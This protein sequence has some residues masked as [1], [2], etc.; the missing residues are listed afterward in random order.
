MAVPN[1]D[2]FVIEDDSEP[3]IV[4]TMV[5]DEDLPPYIT[6]IDVIDQNTPIMYTRDQ[7]MVHVLNTITHNAPV[8]DAAKFIRQ[9]NEFV[10]VMMALSTPMSAAKSNSLLCPILAG[11][12]SVVVEEDE[13]DDEDVLTQLGSENSAPVTMS[14][15]LNKLSKRSN[16]ANLPY[17]ALVDS[18]YKA[19]QTFVSNQD[20][21]AGYPTIQYSFEANTRAF[22]VGSPVAINSHSN[23]NHTVF[24]GNAFYKGDSLN[25]IGFVYQGHRDTLTNEKYELIDSEAYRT[26][27]QALDVGDEVVVYHHNRISKSRCKVTVR[28]PG[29]IEAR[30][31]TSEAVYL[32]HTDSIWKNDAFAFGK[33][34]IGAPFYMGSILA[35]GLAFT[36]LANDLDGSL[37]INS[38]LPSVD[39][40]ISIYNNRNK[41]DRVDI[42][43]ILSE[44]GYATERIA[45]ISQALYATTVETGSERLTKHI[46]SLRDVYV[47][48][49][50]N[51]S[52]PKMRD[53]T[54][55]GYDDYKF[56]KTFCDSEY[57]R[58]KH[59]MSQ[60]DN[61]LMLA[62]AVAMDA[63]KAAEKRAKESSLVEAPVPLADATDAADAADDAEC[64]KKDIAKQCKKT[65]TSQEAM[66][67]DN[68]RR[69]DEV[70]AGDYAK[71]QMDGT[72]QY[73]RRFKT[74][75]GAEE[76]VKDM[77][78]H[79]RSL[80][81][82]DNVVP[83][84]V[85]TLLESGC[86]YDDMKRVCA[87]L[88]GV[89]KKYAASN[90]RRKTEMLMTSK[91]FLE[92]YDVHSRDAAV[93]L[94]QLVDFFNLTRTIAAPPADPTAVVYAL[95]KVDY[96]D[97]VGDE[98]KTDFA[99][100]YGNIN[101]D[102]A[103]AYRPMKPAAAAAADA[104]D[105]ADDDDDDTIVGEQPS[106][107][108]WVKNVV[109]AIGI[110]MTKPSLAYISSQL[111][112]LDISRSANPV[113]VDASLARIKTVTTERGN[114]E[115][116]T[117]ISNLRKKYAKEGKTVT[118]QEIKLIKRQYALRSHKLVQDKT[119]AFKQKVLTNTTSVLF[120]GCALIA[121][122]AVVNESS[123]SFS[124]V[125]KA[126]WTK[127][128]E[129]AGYVAC[130][131]K[132][133]AN[134]GNPYF[135]TI[136][137]M[138]PQD[139]NGKLMDAIKDIVQA[140]ESLRIAYH[141]ARGK[142]TLGASLQ[143]S[144]P[145]EIDWPSFRPVM[146]RSGS[147]SESTGTKTKP[148]KRP[149]PP[150][151]IVN[152][153]AKEV[154]TPVV[155]TSAPVILPP[156]ITIDEAAPSVDPNIP[157]LPTE[158]AAA[159]KSNSLPDLANKT[160]PRLQAVMRNV[161]LPAAEPTFKKF[162]MCNASDASYYKSILMTFVRN[163]LPSII[164]KI[165][166]RWKFADDAAGT[167]SN[168]D[169]VKVATRL[170]ANP[171]GLKKFN[172]A[173]Q[174]N[175]N[176]F[177]GLE[178]LG[179]IDD[180]VNMVYA[181]MFVFTSVLTVLM[182]ASGDALKKDVKSIIECVVTR[183]ENSFIR[184]TFN[185]TELKHADEARREGRKEKILRGLEA[186][187]HES[188]RMF[189]LM[190]NLGISSYENLD[191][192]EGPDAAADAA[193]DAEQADAE[194]AN[195][196]E[197]DAYTGEDGDETGINDDELD[198]DEYAAN[199]GDDGD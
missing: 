194:T 123:V 133:L 182:D 56:V 13:I 69:V 62:L 52:L 77:T 63:M 151:A 34:Y 39:H 61:G 153:M 36:L 30:H 112:A 152:L 181:L 144:I 135:L 21:T 26:H 9:A 82:S 53:I 46:K 100:K 111:D 149:Q 94:R 4:E 67:A 190:I 188:A 103:P 161:G 8:V 22:L 146:S 54:Q 32:I 2:V 24:A 104:A 193:A 148:A 109:T 145:D 138:N 125:H 48:G 136:S 102:D 170:E 12:R 72:T 73:Y 93:W 198:D 44:H 33:T 197:P 165:T 174:S 154:K 1:D 97:F 199:W 137:N 20:D 51:T 168:K 19:E 78:S 50:A 58:M 105:A 129:Y 187:D 81:C 60:G 147:A 70:G 119:D 113:S 164:G 90:A 179:V 158:L 159:I 150:R 184:N 140:N 7:L 65:Y 189:R 171:N 178:R 91:S 122:I 192:G 127:E 128:S 177:D 96:S 16:D 185:K 68:H 142:S 126:C 169:I 117:Y 180:D 173:I 124:M 43:A 38:F 134:Q 64:Q 162:F 66:F 84:D 141:K 110:A 49:V 45:T 101:F 28:S 80:M 85:K 27:L 18:M 118:D 191:G 108:G 3:P 167:H 89:R 6:T 57:H 160:W 115:A 183:F 155:F 75:D 10:D 172:A 92:K 195:A 55:Y 196:K 166:F 76:W 59:V 186:M 15:L 87:S 132:L 121:V 98:S 99:E 86:T 130:V 14:R 23:G 35:Q 88:E 25:I 17:I 71:L 139:I 79:A 175:R 116:A 5:C 40:V 95:P 157:Q 41:A 11:K 83:L 106:M 31:N 120:V 131:M 163:E 176:M 29:H 37:T 114:Q 47:N 42:R 107:S 156:A 143:S 74:S